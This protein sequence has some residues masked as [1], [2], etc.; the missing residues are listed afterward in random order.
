[1]RAFPDLQL[2]LDPEFSTPATAGGPALPGPSLVPPL[3]FDP[4]IGAGLGGTGPI[5]PPGL[6]P[7]NVSTDLFGHLSDPALGA[8]GPSGPRSGMDA[9]SGAVEGL[10]TGPGLQI[11]GR[12]AGFSLGDWVMRF[13][14]YIPYLLEP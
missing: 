5:R 14:P 9:I 11:D 1:M 7:P 2:H 10:G 3:S 4:T 13:R 12:G 6:L 8:A